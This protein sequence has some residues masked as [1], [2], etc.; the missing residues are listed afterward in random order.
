MLPY[1]GLEGMGDGMM[2]HTLDPFGLIPDPF[3][4]PGGYPRDEMNPNGYPYNDQGQPEM[5]PDPTQW[6][7]PNV[8]SG[9][10]VAA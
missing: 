9:G 2:P 7:G 10:G 5:P 3:V 6:A 1:V 8:P 4:G